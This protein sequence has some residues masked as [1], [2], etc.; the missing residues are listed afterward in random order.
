MDRH[1]SHLSPGLTLSHPPYFP[2]FPSNYL[3]AIPFTTKLVVVGSDGPVIDNL[4]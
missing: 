1:L 4:C 2:T 3:A